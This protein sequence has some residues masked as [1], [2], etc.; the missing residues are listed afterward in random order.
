[1]V[2]CDSQ[3]GS[4]NW[5]SPEPWIKK[6]LALPLHFLFLLA[7]SVAFFYLRAG[8]SPLLLVLRDGK[9]GLE[10]GPN[11]MWFPPHSKRLNLPLSLWQFKSLQD[12]TK[13]LPLTM[14]MWLWGKDTC[15]LGLGP[16]LL[17]GQ[18]VFTAEKLTR[19]PLHWIKIHIGKLLMCI[20]ISHSKMFSI[21]TS[22]KHEQRFLIQTKISPACSIRSKSF[23]YDV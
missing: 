14:W 9:Q 15:L 18:A 11:F 12:R 13:H 17:R 22:G 1:M 19:F 4:W 6:S 3:E 10:A 8:N 2:L 20:T 16:Y 23:K 21:S 5:K 7:T